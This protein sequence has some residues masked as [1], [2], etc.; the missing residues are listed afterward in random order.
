MRLVITLIAGML[1]LTACNT[2][3][4]VGEDVEGAG[5]VIQEGAKDTK[6][7]ITN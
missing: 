3:E 7:A 5:E 6:K 2:F 4:G 1:A